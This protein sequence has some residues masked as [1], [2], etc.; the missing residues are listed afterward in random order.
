[1]A[2]SVGVWREIH[3]INNEPLPALLY[4]GYAS[5]PIRC[6]ICKRAF[7]PREPGW[8]YSP[9]EIEPRCADCYPV[10]GNR[11]LPGYVPVTVLVLKD[12]PTYIGPLASA[13]P[14]MCETCQRVGRLGSLCAVCGLATCLDCRESWLTRCPLFCP[15]RVCSNCPAEHRCVNLVH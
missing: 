12:H 4:T 7:H 13:M 5:N 11:L 6:Q 9:V 8:H 2:S 3:E 1:M 14:S 15:Y 10:Q